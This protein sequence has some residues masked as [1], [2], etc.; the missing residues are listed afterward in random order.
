MQ[1]RVHTMAAVAWVALLAGL[2]SIAQAQAQAQGIYSCVD[3]AGRKITADRPIAECTDRP[4]REI[5]P[6]GTV[7]RVVGPSLTAQ[8]RTM[9][10]Q[11]DKAAAEV[12]AREAEEKR[13]D[14]ALLLRYPSRPVHDKERVEALAQIDTVIKAASQRTTELAGQRKAIDADFEFYKS[15]P[16][17]APASLKR[18]LE[19]HDISVAVQKRFIADQDA[20]K[21]RVNM[22]FDEE[23]VKLNQLWAMGGAMPA[24]P[25]APTVKK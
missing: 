1:M 8:E 13:R 7:K 15:D 11:K 21:K 16:A 22:R 19:E 23:L 20:E 10:E 17:K 9:Q 6:S 14:R 24:A 5:N 4:Q 18:R 3:A 12:R 2:C 25:A